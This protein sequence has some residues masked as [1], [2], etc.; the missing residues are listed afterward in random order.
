M[1][2]PS[3][4]PTHAMRGE[5]GYHHSDTN[6]WGDIPDSVV[7]DATH[8]IYTCESARLSRVVRVSLLIHH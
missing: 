8:D 5:I 2:V 1:D 3:P 7:C 6:V 4:G